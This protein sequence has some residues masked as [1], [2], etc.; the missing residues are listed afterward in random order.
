MSKK[1]RVDAGLPVGSVESS[2]VLGQRLNHPATVSVGNP[3]GGSLPR[4]GECQA[5]D[6]GEQGADPLTDEWTDL[7]RAAEVAPW[8]P[9]QVSAPVNEKFKKEIVD[10]LA[11]QSR[12]GGP[13]PIDAALDAVGLGGFGALVE[14]GGVRTI[15]R[16]LDIVRHD[17]PP[18]V[19]A[20][21]L[22]NNVDA[23]IHGAVAVE[24]LPRHWTCLLGAVSACPEG[25]EWAEA[26]LS[27]WCAWSECP[28]ADWMIWAWARATWFRGDGHARTLLAH[29]ANYLPL[30]IAAC[31]DVGAQ[32]EADRLTQA[33]V[34]LDDWARRRSARGSVELFTRERDALS[35]F[36]RDNATQ[37]ARW[38]ARALYDAASALLQWNPLLFANAL[39]SAVEYTAEAEA[40]ATAPAS[41]HVATRKAAALARWAS[42]RVRGYWRPDEHT[43]SFE[44][45]AAAL[46]LLEGIDV[47]DP[48]LAPWRAHGPIPLPDAV[49][50]MRAGMTPE[51]AIKARIEGIDPRTW[52]AVTRARSAGERP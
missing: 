34:E 40:E 27:P 35:V 26:F 42:T 31:V 39:A 30:A 52:H 11:R 46:A 38:A 3:S 6:V 51:R 18:G 16:T 23:L 4:K 17:A 21:G 45:E 15:L 48:E 33:F 47:N 43:L 7:E 10:A 49:A 12:R 14:A 5:G 50:Y 22:R 9:A 44:G 41:K 19:H 28:R 24:G 8:P 13:S 20:E 25:I 2:T 36:V 32:D 37:C 29:V 1:K